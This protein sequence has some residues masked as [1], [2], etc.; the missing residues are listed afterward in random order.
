M[1]R[2]RSLATLLCLT[3]LTGGVLSARAARGADAPLAD[4]VPADALIY[5]GW[6]GADGCP[7]YSGTHLQ[8]VVDKS[9]M[10]EVFTTFLP[11]VIRQVGKMN[12]QAA[13]V[14]DQ[15]LSTA[16]PMWHHPTAFYFSGVDYPD[17]GQPAAVRGHHRNPVPRLALMCDAGPDASD[18]ASQINGLLANLPP[19]AEPKPAVTQTGSLVVLSFTPVEPPASPLSK[20]P[21]FNAAMAQ[22]KPVGAAVVA[23]G[24]MRRVVAAIDDGVAHGGDPDVSKAWPKIRDAL[25]LAGFRQF[26]MTAGFDGRDWVE[27]EFASTDGSHTGLQALLDARPLDA[28]LLSVVP[29]SADRV[30]AARLDLGAGYDAIHDAI[31]QFDPDAAQQ[32]DQTIAQINSRAGLNLRRDLIG[33][34]GDQWIGYSDKGV[35]GNGI[36]GMVLVNRLRDPAR[37]D[38]AMMQVSHRLNF[39]IAHEMQNPNVTIQF[40]ESTVNGTVLHYLAVPLVT[41][42]WAIKGGYLYVGLYPQVVAAA[43]EAK[44]GPSI[45]TKP[46][47]TAMLR[48]LGDHPAATVSF[49]DLPT[50]APDAYAD[51]LGGVRLWLGMGDLFGANAPV[52]AVPELKQIMPE[53]TPSGAVTWADSAGWHAMTVSPF[54]GAEILGAGSGGSPIQ[55]FMLLGSL[56]QGMQAMRMA[57]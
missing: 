42:T 40:R 14:M 51:L 1:P 20:S 37:A 33:S 6:T 19:D 22:C 2:R 31:G 28:D 38:S 16:S 56:G 43:V 13:A 55:Q 36:M 32:V 15:V 5:V 12:D 18:L 45:L 7:G 24:D 17:G 8:A 39:L 53:L 25:G 35:G 54:P 10:P 48:R 41:P 21:E 26:A 9:S 47:F 46:A 52:M 29:Q 27:R 57:R 50:V 11:Q 49:V 23:Y 34:L 3:A 30:S 4:R 44:G